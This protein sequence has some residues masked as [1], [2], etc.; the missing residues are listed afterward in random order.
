MSLPKLLIVCPGP[1]F[2]QDMASRVR[3]LNILKAAKE[4]FDVTFLANCEPP[5][6]TQNREQ[7]KPIC[8]QVL[9]L[10]FRNKINLCSRVLHRIR[11][12]LVHHTFGVPYDLYYSGMINLSS[13]AI[14]DAIRA[15][16]FDVVLFEYWFGSNSAEYFKNEGIPCI[17]DMHD[18][19]WQK[20]TGVKTTT[21]ANSFMK[22]HQSF[23]NGK[24]RS[25]EEQAWNRFDGIIAINNHEHNYVCSKINKA[26]PMLNAGTGVDINDWPYCW[27]P[28]YPSRIVFYGALSGKENQHAALRC[29]NQIMP[30]VWQRIPMTEF[31]IVGANPPKNLCK[32]EI[33]PL[34]KVTGFVED[35]KTV[36]SQATLLLC[37]LVGKYGFRSR[38]IEA[39]A[40]GLPIITSNDA[41]YGMD[42]DNNQGLIASDSDNV[43]ADTAIK[44]L[45]LPDFARRQSLLARMQVERKFSFEATYDRIVSFLLSYVKTETKCQNSTAINICK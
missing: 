12:A 7:L 36:L 13:S 33:N 21:P 35:V 32:L 3:V 19:I 15:K 30:F 37:P 11:S 38:L 42:I 24:Y 8:S 2:P 16:K 18:V 9:L 39:M 41:V 10:P 43:M 40:L 27:N 6:I 31:W 17:L 25:F 22:W 29:V 20:K 23:L 26:P 4:K 34:I 44:F 28:S 14:K 5:F 45:T 1:L